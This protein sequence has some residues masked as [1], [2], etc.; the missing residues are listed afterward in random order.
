MS[1][2][3]EEDRKRE[4]RRRMLGPDRPEHGGG[5]RS[6][7]SGW[8]ADVGCCSLEL[9]GALSAFAGLTLYS[10]LR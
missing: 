6:P 1:E 2:Q 8:W 7:R 4:A 9:F 3:T 10:M 5:Y